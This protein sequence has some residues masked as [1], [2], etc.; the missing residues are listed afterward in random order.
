MSIRLEKLMLQII[1]ILQ[2]KMEKILE[3]LIMQMKLV[4]LDGYIEETPYMM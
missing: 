4:S 1:K 3:D 2:Q